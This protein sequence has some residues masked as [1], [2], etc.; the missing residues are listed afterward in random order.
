M[1]TEWRLGCVK[2]QIALAHNTI[3]AHHLPQNG[4]LKVEEIRSVASANPSVG[5]LSLHFAG[6]FDPAARQ[7]LI[8][9][10]FTE[11]FAIARPFILFSSVC[12]K[13]TDV[14]R[15]FDVVFGRAGKLRIQLKR[16]KT[17]GAILSHAKWHNQIRICFVPYSDCR[18]AG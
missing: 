15:T 3:R 5:G 16:H 17:I 10:P 4:H 13:Y 8:A 12:Y 6:S 2:S 18:P 9:D 11:S 1:H 14:P 7:H